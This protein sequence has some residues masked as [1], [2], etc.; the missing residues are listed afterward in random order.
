MGRNGDSRPVRVI[1]NVVDRCSD[2]PFPPVRLR[3]RWN[4]RDGSS[5]ASAARNRLSTSAS[6]ALMR[7]GARDRALR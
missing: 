1:R 2:R 7:A 3:R 5:T 6:M 4:D